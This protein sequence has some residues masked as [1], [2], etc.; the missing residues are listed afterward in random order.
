[1]GL[2]FLDLFRRLFPHAVIKRSKST[3]GKKS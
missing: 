1:M 3:H 2:L